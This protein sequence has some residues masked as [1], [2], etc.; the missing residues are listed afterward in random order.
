MSMLRYWI[1]LA[2]VS[3]VGPV[4]A[5]RLLDEFG[6]P[7]KVFFAREDDYKK[8]SFLTKRDIACLCRKNM[9]DTM[10]IVNTTLENNYSII[11][12]SDIQYPDRLK[13]IFDPPIV[14][15][16][17]GQL[18]VIDEEAAIA[19]VG[20][21]RCSVYGAK[22]AERI[23]YEITKSG[24]IVVSGLALGIDSAAARGALRAG[25]QVVGV[26]GSG[27]DIVYPRENRGLF[28]DI[29]QC[30]AIV[31]EYP[32]G[33]PAIGVHFPQRNRIISGLSLGVTVVEAPKSSGALITASR[34]LEQG[35]DVFAV[36]GNIDAPTC[37]GSNALLKEGALP[38]TSGRDIINEYISVYPKLK[39]FAKKEYIP[40][41]ES[42][43]NRL[44]EKVSPEVIRKPIS[45]K[46][47]IDKGKDVEYID[48][49]KLLEGLGEDE[50]AVA[51]VLNGVMHVDDIIEKSGIPAARVL[52]ALTM[53][54]I[55]GCVKQQSGKRFY[56]NISEK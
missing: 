17:K 14:L 44:T 52:S 18:P 2:S 9:N 1:W 33:S 47:E 19:V 6:T 49:V 27:L 15:Y 39:K 37:E 16:V 25:G 51:S 12:L 54:E 26:I 45:S 11:T 53:L 43:Q 36:P 10:R 4:T 13:N 7:D 31:S 3:G 50:K 21:R 22:A 40:L 23:G 29:A 41:D 34:A 32:V 46:K 35:R 56:L 8:Y 30:G 28:N 38:V 24:G 48:V 42:E 20:T 55:S 5:K